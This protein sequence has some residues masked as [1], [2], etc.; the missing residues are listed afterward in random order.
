[1]REQGE[2]PQVRN[3][4][5]L[6]Y[7]RLREVNL[8][9]RSPD[10]ALAAART[11]VDLFEKLVSAHPAVAEYQHNLAYAYEDGSLIPAL[12]AKQESAQRALAIRE[13]LVRQ[14]PEN[15]TYLSALAFSYYNLAVYEQDNSRP[16]RALEFLAKAGDLRER[17]RNNEPTNTANLS[18]LALTYELMQ[19]M[20]QSMGGVDEGLHSLEQARTIRQEL[21][22]RDPNETSFQTGLA[23][24][25]F[26]LATAQSD[27]DREVSYYRQAC[28]ILEKQVDRIAR[29]HPT[30][31]VARR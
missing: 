25:Y 16:A 2:E 10:A 29:D 14:D 30:I 8:D 28:E 27:H 3:R 17:Q 9:A 21:V 11:A 23:D 31:A 6:A 18:L 19:R 5:G 1:T 15:S 12:P 7:S 13:Q 24:C 22:R 20:Q 4:L 26:A